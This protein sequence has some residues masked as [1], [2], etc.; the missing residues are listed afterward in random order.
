MRQCQTLE[1]PGIEAEM[2]QKPRW[3]APKYEAAGK[4]EGKVAL[5]T[6]GDS[7]IGRA[8]DWI[9]QGR[10]RAPALV[11][12]GND[13]AGGVILQW[14]GWPGGA[15]T[16]GR[17]RG[18]QHQPSLIEESRSM[19]RTHLALLT[20]LILPFLAGS[21]PV[22]AQDIAAGPV[23]LDPPARSSALRPTVATD[24]DHRFAVAWR[25]L[26]ARGQEIRAAMIDAATGAI[27]HPDVVDPE[28][29]PAIEVS[30]PAVVVQKGGDFVAL[31]GWG[32]LLE[33]N[34]GCVFTRYIDA[35]SPIQGENQVTCFAT[36]AAPQVALVELPGQGFAVVWTQPVGP[37]TGQTAVFLRLLNFGGLPL[38][39]R[40]RVWRRSP[41]PQVAPQVLRDAGGRLLVAWQQPW[42]EGTPRRLARRFGP[43]AAPLAPAF[44][45]ETGHF[46][47][48]RPRLAGA[49]D[50][51]FAAAWEEAIGDEQNVIVAQ[52]NPESRFAS[53]S[54]E[55]SGILSD[56]IGKPDLAMDSRGN[57]VVAWEGIGLGGDPDEGVIARP[58]NAAGQWQGDF[59]PDGEP[60]RQ[61]S[62][63][64]ALSDAGLVLLAWESQPRPDKRTEV[65]AQL[66][67]V[68]AGNAA[69]PK[70]DELCV[71]HRNTF[72]CSGERKI[73]FGDGNLAG[74]PFLADVDG[75]GDD[76]PCLRSGA[77]FLCDT[78]H[79]GGDA[80]VA[81]PFG[82]AAQFPLMGDVDGDGRDDPCV[83]RGRS[84]LC[85]TA[86]DGGAPEFRLRFGAGGI[87]PFLGDM[88][89]DGD[90]DPCVFLALTKTLACDTSHDGTQDLS[91]DMTSLLP[92]GQ[93][94]LG[95]TDGDGRDEPCVQIGSELL[96]DPSHTG[97]P[98]RYEL[99]IILAGDAVVLGNI[100]GL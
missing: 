84:W 62:P 45:L 99:D 46:F 59:Q 16:A 51:R 88:D 34:F 74:F 12:A 15:G 6:G 48:G 77:V 43:D 68:P 14:R 42:P 78:A 9:D 47:T 95:D 72:R 75:D 69:L 98:V 58:I 8:V 22:A 94:V 91:L 60:G 11:L 5:V 29:G 1:K 19:K 87:A 2:Q 37:A 41:G 36:T 96:C 20:I 28:P 38:S 32:E 65:H 66:F 67:A 92:G 85:D 100:D 57:V 4:L 21:V 18:R 89:G 90:D 56:G 10:R 53:A 35:F 82:T 25:S 54:H 30:R 33:P 93:I 76:D 40:L 23:R 13:L 79:D 80:E 61:G 52:F 81:L 3:R 55:L 26:S 97:V 64:V 44:Q 71:Y 7:G 24:G 63:A 83:R 50:G 49:P 27:T 17:A 39:P 31:I 70:G 86:H 73:R